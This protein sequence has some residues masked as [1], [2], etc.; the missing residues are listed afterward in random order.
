MKWKEVGV[1]SIL[2]ENLT[3][4]LKPSIE[5][6]MHLSI[7]RKNKEVRAVIHAHPVF[8]SSFTAMKCNINTD[9]TAEAA[10]ILGTPLIG[11]ICS[12]GNC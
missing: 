8:A 11:F 5:S 2:G 12:Y 9:L 4:N 3:P 7:Y 6:E 10:A 1:M